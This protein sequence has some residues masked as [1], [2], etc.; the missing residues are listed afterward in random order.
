MSRKLVVLIQDIKGL[1]GRYKRVL[2][3]WASFANNDGTNIFASKETVAGRAGVSRWT[4]YE[5][6]DVLETA[7][8]IQRTSSHSCKTEKCNKGGTHY[9]SQHGQYTQVYRINVALL[10][11]PTVLLEKLADPTV[12]KPRKVTVGKRQKGTV[13]KP[14]ATRAIE[15]TPAAAGHDQL[16]VDT[17][18]LVP[19]VEGKNERKNEVS[20]ATLP[21]HEKIPLPHENLKPLAEKPTGREVEQVNGH[22]Y[23]FWNEKTKLWFIEYEDG[24]GSDI[25]AGIRLVREYGWNTVWD[26]LV[27]TWQCPKTAGIAWKDFWYWCAQ[28][29]LTRRTITTW[30]NKVFA[31]QQAQIA[32]CKYCQMNG[33]C[34]AH[35]NIQCGEI[36]TNK[37]PKCFESCEGR[38]CGECPKCVKEIVD[39]A[40]GIHDEGLPEC[41]SGI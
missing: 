3:A 39:N 36:E 38:G 2:Q 13:V 40:N 11:N 31:Q 28:F 27:A 19:S 9:T 35:V 25:N 18:P 21:Q 26:T 17:S 15:A 12:V 41:G 4:V 30:R 7:G 22:M 10:E 34:P 14:D 8:V 23:S 20:E 29:D 5:N 6:T 24:S 32:T 37:A 16:S 1:P 33:T